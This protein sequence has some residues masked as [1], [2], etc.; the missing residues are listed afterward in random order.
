MAY[1]LALISPSD[2]PIYETYLTSSKPH[3]Q[4]ASSSTSTFPSWSSFPTFNN[5]QHNAQPSS[6]SASAGQPPAIPPKDPF[7]P[8][9]LGGPGTP[10]KPTSGAI[11]NNLTGQPP[12]G[13]EKHVM[14]MIAFSSLDIVEDVMVGTG[15]MYLKM[16]DKFNEWNVSAFVAPSVKLI[17]LHDI[18]ND[19]G[20]R[21]FFMD[22]W[23]HYVKTALNPFHTPTTRITS[24][25]FDQRV[26]ASAKRHL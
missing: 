9:F 14:Q 2:S 25:L 7:P 26:R 10:S 12:Q 3:N 16:I 24:T 20:I 19:E 22:V 23:E 5:N 6:A 11:P 13:V 18:K 21:L 4:I 17:I 8:Q 15:S 1:Y